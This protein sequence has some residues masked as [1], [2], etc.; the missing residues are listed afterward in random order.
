LKTL[1]IREWNSVTSLPGWIGNFPDLIDLDISLN[2]NLTGPVR[3]YV[4]LLLLNYI[5]N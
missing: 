2:P 3:R 1:A 4:L 5:S